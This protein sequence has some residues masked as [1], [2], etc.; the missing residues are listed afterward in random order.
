MLAA[1]T[2]AFQY[3]GLL[4]DVSGLH[5]INNGEGVGYS[6]IPVDL[7][8]FESVFNPATPSGSCFYSDAFY[9]LHLSDVGRCPCLSWRGLTGA[10]SGYSTDGSLQV[11]ISRGTL[12]GYADVDA[13]N[14]QDAYNIARHLIGM[15]GGI[16]RIPRVPPSKPRRPHSSL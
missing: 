10:A 12:L 6:I 1:V 13:F 16:I 5:L 2:G 8:S 7:D 4:G 15:I 9:F 14:T 3:Y 11:V